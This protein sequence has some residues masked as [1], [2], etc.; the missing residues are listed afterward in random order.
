VAPPWDTPRLTTT[1]EKE[2]LM[3][4]DTKKRKK[5]TRGFEK[6]YGREKFI[7]FLFKKHRIGFD[8]ITITRKQNTPLNV[9][10]I[11]RRLICRL[12]SR[13]MARRN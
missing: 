13:T 4:L 5:A 7:F 6:V 1:K 8:P 10:T 2:P 12:L 9:N 3:K 11:M